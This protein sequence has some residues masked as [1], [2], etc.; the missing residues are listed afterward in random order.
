MCAG[1]KCSG[2][3]RTLGRLTRMHT[4]IHTHTRTLAHTH[5]YTDTHIH[6]HTNTTHARIHTHAHIHEQPK[7]CADLKC[8][9]F[10]RTTWLFA[11]THMH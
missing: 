2:V 10:S 5:T 6:I 4:Y 11:H 3:S 1:L 8:S 9:S 7:S